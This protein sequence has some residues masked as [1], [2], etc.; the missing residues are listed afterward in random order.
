MTTPED[1]VEAAAEALWRDRHQRFEDHEWA[2]VAE[3]TKADYR[4]D[5]RVVLKAIEGVHV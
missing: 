1:V 3:S 4:A 2:H 5:V